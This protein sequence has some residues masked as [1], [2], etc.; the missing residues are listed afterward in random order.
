[1][2]DPITSHKRRVICYWWQLCEIQS[3]D[4]KVV[5][6]VTGDSYVRSNHQTQRSCYLLLV[7]VMCD[8]ITRHKRRVICYWWQLCEIQSPDTNVVL[9]VTGDSY[10]RSN[11]QTQTSCYLLLVTVMWELITRHKGRVICY[12]WQ[13]CVI[14]SPDTNVVLSVTGD[15]YVWSYHQTHTS[16]NLLLVTFTLEPNIRYNHRVICYS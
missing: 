16:Y 5:L 8:P 9:S 3:P 13:L 14:L 12:W 2:C 4:T 15:S 1:M 10:V 6:S 7:T 11:H